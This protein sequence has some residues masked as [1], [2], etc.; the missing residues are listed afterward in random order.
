MSDPSD[1]LRLRVVTP[2]RSLVDADVESVSLPGI[3]GQIGILPGHRPMMSALG[4]G[5]IEY[6]Y[7][8]RDESHEVEGG[9][10]E[11]HPNRVLVFTRLAE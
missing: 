5:A 10:A 2:R 8:G 1:R 4:R 6:R 11:I 7:G 9:Y 3:D